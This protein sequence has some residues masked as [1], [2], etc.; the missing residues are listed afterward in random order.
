MKAILRNFKDDKLGTAIEAK[1]VSISYDTPGIQIEVDDYI[2]VY[3]TLISAG[4]KVIIEGKILR[5]DVR[6]ITCFE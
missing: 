6:S 1:N 2:K 3:N 4:Y 5:V